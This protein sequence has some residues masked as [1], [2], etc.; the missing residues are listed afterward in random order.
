MIEAAMALQRA[1]MG[2][3]QLLNS[4][5]G[6]LE[7]AAQRGFRPLF[8]EHFREVSTADDS[9]CGRGLRHRERIVIEDVEPDPGFASHRAVAAAAGHRAVQP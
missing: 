1:D 4:D 3:I 7:I 5:Q 2:N 8:L 6:V 9:A